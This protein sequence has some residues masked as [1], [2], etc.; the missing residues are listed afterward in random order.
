MAE[1]SPGTRFPAGLLK[2]VARAATDEQVERVGIHWAAQQAMELL[3]A[4]VA[5]VH[6]YTLNQSRAA[7]EIYRSLGIDHSEQL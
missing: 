7:R 1:L 4:D 3:A 2:S 6:F 5:G